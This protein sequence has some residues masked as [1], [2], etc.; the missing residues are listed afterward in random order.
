MEKPAIITIDDA[1]VLRA[2]ERDLRR[3]Y[4]APIT[5]LAFTCGPT[6]LIETVATYLQELGYK[7]ERVKTE[8]FG[9]TGN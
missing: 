9:P 6:A 8:R 5:P 7:P 3:K 4:A 2:I 1:E